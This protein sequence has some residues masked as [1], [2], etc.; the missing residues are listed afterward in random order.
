[1]P[2]NIMFALIYHRHKLLEAFN[3]LYYVALNDRIKDKAV[4]VLN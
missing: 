4:P 1:M 3:S 2:R